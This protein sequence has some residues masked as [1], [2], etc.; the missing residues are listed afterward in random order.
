MEKEIGGEHV[1]FYGYKEPLREIMGGFGYYGTLAY[2]KDRDKV[3][4]HLCGKMFGALRMHIIRTHKMSVINYKVKIGLAQ[5]TALISEGTRRKL[6]QNAYPVWLKTTKDWDK[7]AQA[8]KEG[9]EK[10]WASKPERHKKPLE[11]FNK[12]G[13][14]PDQLLDIIDRTIKSFGRTPTYKEFKAFHHGRYSKIILATYGTWSNAL[15]KLG[16]KTV[17]IPSYDKEELLNS[18]REFYAIN[19][20]T[21]RWSDFKR[22]LISGYGAY[23]RCFGTLNN[24]RRAANV[25]IIVQHGRKTMEIG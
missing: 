24:A 12:T 11:S 2:S 8:R 16:K 18:M 19:R 15:S 17:H 3:Q 1:Y 21:A 25:P 4:C 5:G 20:R 22:G 9:R 23:L 10:F 7:F 6:I 14:C 13:T